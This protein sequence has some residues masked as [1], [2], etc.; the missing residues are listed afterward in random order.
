MPISV[1]VGKEHKKIFRLKKAEAH[2]NNNN[3]DLETTL[4]SRGL[5]FKEPALGKD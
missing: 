2:L 4:E 5:K 3:Q 1:A